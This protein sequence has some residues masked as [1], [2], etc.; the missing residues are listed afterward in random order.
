MRI[1]LQVPNFTWPGGPEAM[2]GTLRQIA[3]TVDEGGFASL[4]VMD[5]LFQIPMVGPAETDMLEG[6]GALHYLAGIT[7]RVRLGTMVT[8]VTYRHPG[9]LVK[10]VSTLD[11]LSGGRATLGI[12][13]AWFDREHHGLGIPY[14]SLGERFERLEETLQIAEQMWSDD[15]GPFDGHHYQ[16]AETLCVPQPLQR[17]RPPILI[18]GM[19][20]RKTLR[21]V[22]LYADACNLFAHVGMDELARKLDVLRGHCD[23][24]ERDFDEIERTSLSTIQLGPEHMSIPDV[25]AHFRELAELGIQQAIVNLPNVHDI[26]PLETLAKEIIPEVGGF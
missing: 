9:V 26:A 10:T 19:G 17:P 24:V 15:D 13:A 6:Y 16:L 14:P 8:G 7:R 11:V 12:G 18:G 21:L 1:G 4:W 5:H 22:A 25:I 20:E 3:E 23:D 2:A